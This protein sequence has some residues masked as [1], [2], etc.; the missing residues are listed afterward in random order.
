MMR[1]R[2]RDIEARQK[3][4][5][6]TPPS[7][8]QNPDPDDFGYPLTAPQ[9]ARSPTGF[10]KPIPESH[11]QEV[12]HQNDPS[13][14]RENNNNSAMGWSGRTVTGETR[15]TDEP[16]SPHSASGSGFWKGAPPPEPEIIPEEPEETGE[17]DLQTDNPIQRQHSIA[18]SFPSLYA[19]EPSRPPPLPPIP[20]PPI[21][22]G[23]RTS[24][25]STSFNGR[26][27]NMSSKA[28]VIMV[29]REQEH[30]PEEVVRIGQVP[31]GRPIPST[32]EAE[33]YPDDGESYRSNFLKM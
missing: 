28:Q 6:L 5:R 33:L 31:T 32:P 16:A 21:E 13:L 3:I 23:V 2:K 20:N 17:T 7:V 19:R 15:H 4:D 25:Q 14:L 11:T 29:G 10:L 12:P 24:L 27:G 8:S 22:L 9:T 26:R 1:R 18:S 30:R